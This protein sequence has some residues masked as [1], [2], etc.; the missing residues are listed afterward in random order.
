MPDVALLIL[1]PVTE[2]TH[3]EVDL[4]ESRNDL[5]LLYI[6]AGKF[7]A[8][9]D[10]LS[11]ERVEKADIQSAFHFAM[12]SWGLRGSAGSE[13]FAKVIELHEA[14]DESDRLSGANYFLCIG[15][16]YWVVGDAEQAMEYA[17]LALNS[18]DPNDELFSS[19]RYSDVS[20]GDFQDD[21]GE[22]I[23]LFS[24]NSRMAPPCVS[25]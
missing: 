18:I 3:H 9:A 6:A 10:L 14:E 25:A 4:G 21:V 11:H 1:E 12:A 15:L 19:W 2:D 17:E 16:A 8:A 20:V 13:A 24:G 5:A 23:E 7:K 22:M